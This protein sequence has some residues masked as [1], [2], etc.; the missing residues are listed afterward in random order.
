MN[1]VP[2]S[3]A[4]K[5][6]GCDNQIFHNEKYYGCEDS[7]GYHNN[8][9]TCL[10]LQQSNLYWQGDIGCSTVVGYLTHLMFNVCP[11]PDIVLSV[12]VIQSDRHL[13]PGRHQKMRPKGLTRRII[14]GSGNKRL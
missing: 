10:S 2:V 3:L 8:C 13:R 7:F 11:L 12:T 4:S 5:N 14:S 1:I 6:E 9:A